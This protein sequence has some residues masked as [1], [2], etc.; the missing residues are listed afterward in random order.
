MEH[1][2]GLDKK[3]AMFSAQKMSRIQTWPISVLRKRAK[4]SNI[5]EKR[6]MNRIRDFVSMSSAQQQQTKHSIQFVFI[7]IVKSFVSFGK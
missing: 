6:K 7:S 4:Q 2:R 5:R 3:M 1:S